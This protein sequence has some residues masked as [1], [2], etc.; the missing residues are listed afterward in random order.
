MADH[1]EF[2]ELAKEL[3]AEEGRTITLQ[4]LDATAAD[5]SKPWNGPGVP[6]V[7]TEYVAVPAVFVPAYGRDL[8]M[9]VKDDELLKKVKQVALVSPVAEGLH[10]KIARIVDTDGSFWKVSWGQA[11]RPANQTIIYLFGVEQ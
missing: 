4:E 3:L 9:L 6:T 7:K 1:T 11:L 5:P 2:V 8:S 10:D